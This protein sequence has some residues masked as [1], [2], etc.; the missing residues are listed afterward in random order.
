MHFIASS[1]RRLLAL[2]GLVFSQVAGAGP[3]LGGAHEGFNYP[4]GTEIT[5]TN[6]LT[7]GVGW[8][9]TGDSNLPNR[10]T[11]RWADATALPAAGG[12][13]PAKKVLYPTL[14]YTAIG[15]PISQ[16]G[17]ATI[18]ALPANATNNVSRNF[19]Q[20]V[21]TGTFYFSYLTDKNNDTQ[22]T[23]SLGFFGPANGVT[24]TPGN[25]PERFTFGQIGTGTAGNVNT[26]GNF[27]CSSTTP[28]QPTS[29][30]PPTPSPTA[31]I[32]PT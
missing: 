14:S 24:G 18:D 3:M 2:P 9:A 16:G 15:Y 7:G 27:A 17:K 11:S 22:R 23:T 6:N 26:L 5:V 29:L 1:A 13:G 30:R 4:D 10:A 28:I 32:S 8:N 25:T 31:L 19:Q 21:D 20:L 12:T